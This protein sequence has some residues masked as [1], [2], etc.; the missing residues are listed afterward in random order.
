MA[1]II[2]PT[3]PN[4]KAVVVNPVPPVPFSAIAVRFPVKSR[5]SAIKLVTDLAPAGQ[6][7]PAMVGIAKATALSLIESFPAT[8]T[9]V[10][11]IIETNAA[12]ARQ[13]MVCVIPHEL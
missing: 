4:A 6:P 12:K 10:E 13:L 3:Q 1:E 11:V 9:G 8:V 7:D 2:T 5:A